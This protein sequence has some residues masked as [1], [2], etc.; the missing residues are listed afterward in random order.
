MG[1][2]KEL[3]MAM[4]DDQLM[5]G[6]I[7]SMLRLH[8]ELYEKCSTGNK[9]EDFVAGDVVKCTF[10]KK[11][12]FRVAGPAIFDRSRLSLYP[13]DYN[14]DYTNISPEFLKKVKI[15]EKAVKVLYED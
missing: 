4:N 15:S 12:L 8:P 2:F 5:V 6:T 1:K 9:I 10:L 11:G 13:I 14:G 3:I 7:E